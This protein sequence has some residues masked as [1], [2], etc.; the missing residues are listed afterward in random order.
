MQ[1]HIT[2]Y[3]DTFKQKYNWANV[4]SN[5]DQDETKYSDN[6]AHELARHGD[7]FNM[8]IAINKGLNI[9]TPNEIG[10]YPVHEAASHNH[11]KMMKLLLDN[12]SY[13]DERIKPFGHTP[14]YLAVEKGYHDMAKFLIQNKAKLYVTDLLTGRTLLH[15]A[16]K[17]NDTK[18]VNLL[19]N[20]G[21]NTLLCDRQELTA[22]DIAAKNNN[23][24]L[25]KTL[26]NAMQHHA[27]LLDI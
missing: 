22:R 27:M 13:I 24:E 5:I 12:G 11:L 7:I 8:E 4:I 26:L 20:A 15:I 19:I 9:N 14:L 21:I 1:R 23:K 16:A 18:M 2:D 3:I 17:N 10:K 25:E 6:Y